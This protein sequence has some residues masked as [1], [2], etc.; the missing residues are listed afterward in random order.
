VANA[1]AAVGAQVRISTFSHPG[2]WS[3]SSTQ[4]VHVQVRHGFTI[5]RLLLITRR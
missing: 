5:V 2:G 4:H 1:Q 3:S